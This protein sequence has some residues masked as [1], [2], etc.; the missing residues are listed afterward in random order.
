MSSNNNNKDPMIL[1]KSA[2]QGDTKQGGNF[3]SVNIAPK[4]A[5]E[6]LKAI[7]ESIHDERGVQLMLTLSERVNKNTGEAFTGA[8]I[9]VREVQEFSGKKSSESGKRSY[10]NGA[11]SG[12]ADRVNSLRNGRGSRRGG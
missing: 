2:R 9:F 11:G 3:V 7:E 10:N 5:D 12:A 8:V 6:L 1:C 4:E